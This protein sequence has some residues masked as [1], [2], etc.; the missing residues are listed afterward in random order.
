MKLVFIT[1]A[2][3]PITGGGQKL[4]EEVLTRL[5]RAGWKITVVTRLLPG[6]FQKINCPNLTI[7]R[8][9][10]KLPFFNLFGRGWFIFAAFGYCLKLKPEI[11]F[12]TTWL[13]AITLQLIK[14]IKPKIP[15]VLLAIGF[16]S[17]FKSLE[18]LITKK[19]K[20]DLV[21]TDD[22][23]FKA[24]NFIP[25][26]VDLPRKQ[27]VAKWRDFTFLF[28][29]RNEP[30]KGV[31]VLNQAF[32]QVKRHYP[33]ARLRLFG[34]GFQ[35]ISQKQ[36]D[37][38]LFKAHCLVL[39]SLREG[40]PLILFEAWAHRLPVIA[41][42]VGSVPQ[43]VKPANGYLVPAGNATALAAAMI[44]AINDKNLAQKGQVGFNLAK[45]YTWAKT[46]K[47]Y[48]NNLKCLLKIGRG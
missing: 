27:S 34:P 38:E 43:F 17:R 30:R 4:Y 44:T 46:A 40:H 42:G 5:A 8:L 41:A 12:A 13:P 23:T 37:R 18:D 10:P 25:N 45:N 48:A 32:I 39:P 14:L 19:F 35:L 2:W 26:G 22:W 15:A 3:R 24:A 21:L 47:K 33:Q 9:G 20:Y 16:G 11:F 31:A 7:I 1:D 29:G 36:L 28:V 6:V